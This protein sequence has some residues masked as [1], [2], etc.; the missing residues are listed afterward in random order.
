[1]SSDLKF[2]E[3][4]S[5]ALGM[6]YLFEFEEGD[7]FYSFEA[8]LGGLDYNFSFDIIKDIVKQLESER[9]IDVIFLP[10]V[11]FA[12]ILSKGLEN[13]EEFNDAQMQE[14]LTLRD[15]VDKVEFDL[16]LNELDRKSKFSKHTL[17]NVLEDIRDLI[18]EY[19]GAKSDLHKD[20]KIIRLELSKHHPDN[21][22]LDYKVEI[23]SD[24]NFLK[25]VIEKLK[26]FL[27][28]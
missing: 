4:A 15:Q 14:I 23:L 27:E 2:S 28:Y 8:I 9:L 21:E 16:S 26:S 7:S 6:L 12:R 20:V 1:M 17:N 11:V 19:G 5:R 24:I 13:I 3:A 18:D 25:P 22:V 10:G